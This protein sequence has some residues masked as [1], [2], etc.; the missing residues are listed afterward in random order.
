MCPKDL[1]MTCPFSSYLRTKVHGNHDGT[2]S[3][4]LAQAHIPNTC[5]RQRAVTAIA[6]QTRSVEVQQCAG[7]TPHRGTNTT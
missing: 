1:S 5:Y 4:L 6:R 3:R 2:L 7:E